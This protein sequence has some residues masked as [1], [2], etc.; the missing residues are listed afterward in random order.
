M[1]TRIEKEKL[2][3]DDLKFMEL[4]QEG[5]EEKIPLFRLRSPPDESLDTC[6]VG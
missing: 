2:M 3:V 5:D 4:V 6:L 1:R